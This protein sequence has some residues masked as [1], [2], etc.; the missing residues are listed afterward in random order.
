VVN[1]GGRG[2]SDQLWG[3]RLYE[4][5]AIAA[6]ISDQHDDLIEYLQAKVDFTEPDPPDPPPWDP[7]DL[8]DDG[9]D[10]F[11]LDPSDLSTMFRNTLGTQP[12]TGAGQQVRR[13]NDK[14][15]NNR[16]ALWPHSGD[17]PTLLRRANGA[18]FL[19]MRSGTQG[20]N[21]LSMTNSS[22]RLFRGIGAFTLGTANITL[23]FFAANPRAVFFSTARAPWQTNQSHVVLAVR[24]AH[25]E[26]GTQRVVTMGGVG[27]AS[28]QHFTRT[29]NVTAGAAHHRPNLMLTSVQMLDYAAGDHKWQLNGVSG[30]TLNAFAGSNTRLTDYNVGV[31]TMSDVFGWLGVA[32]D[33]S[34]DFDNITDYLDDRMGL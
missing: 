2:V 28:N 12:V 30:Q 33:A 10:G 3:G 19:R 11:W 14:S 6:D 23:R 32:K 7:A 9:S 13:I 31:D 22:S 17:A 26:N 34:D 29:V 24:A 1:V 27:T 21:P 4:L 18:W 16:H 20:G 5:V 15:G 25:L 8:F